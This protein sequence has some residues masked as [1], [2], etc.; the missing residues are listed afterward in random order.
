MTPSF[1]H[2][3]LRTIFYD[4]PFFLIVTTIVLNV[5]TAVLI[6]RFSD[7]RG[8]RV[9]LFIDGDQGIVQYIFMTRTQLKVKRRKHV[10]FVE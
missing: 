8:E 9:S 7:L 10:S 2:Y 4:L 3:S 1:T 5:V 6:D